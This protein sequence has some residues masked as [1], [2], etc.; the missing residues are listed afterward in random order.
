MVSTFFTDMG[1]VAYTNSFT[2]KD[3]T[4]KTSLSAI[5]TDPILQADAQ[6][7]NLIA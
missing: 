6:I 5:A 1:D 4:F 2:V 3:R 7:I